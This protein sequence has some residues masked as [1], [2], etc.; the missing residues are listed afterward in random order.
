M[1]LLSDGVN[2]YEIHRIGS[3]VFVAPLASAALLV[4]G[5]MLYALGGDAATNR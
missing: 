2:A 5:V 1:A 4:A 3:V